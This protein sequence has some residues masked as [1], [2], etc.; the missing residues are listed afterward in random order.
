VKREELEFAI[1]AATEIIRQREVLVIGSQS[2]LGSFSEAELPER[3]TMSNEAGMAPL[4]DDEAETLATLIDAALGV[5]SDFDRDHGFYVQGVSV[6]TAYLPDGWESRVMRVEPR[7]HPDSVGLCLERHD[8]CAAKLARFDQKDL[9]F[10]D[11]LIDSGLVVPS[12][13]RERLALITD[14]RFEPERKATATRWMRAREG[15]SVLGV[16][17]LRRHED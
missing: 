8:L 17:A 15:P 2:I 12:V 11:A 6:R 14:K 16:A 10:V 7:G 5:W 9:E 3:A 4:H 1:V 13:I